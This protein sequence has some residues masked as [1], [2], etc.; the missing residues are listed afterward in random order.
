MTIKIIQEL[1][2]KGHMGMR[3]VDLCD[4]HII[5]VSTTKAYELRNSFLENLARKLDLDV[6]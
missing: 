3:I 6:M 4:E 5:P 2:F 1:Y